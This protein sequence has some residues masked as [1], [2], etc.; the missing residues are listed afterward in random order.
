MELPSIEKCFYL[1]KVIRTHGY[2][3]AL[4]IALDVDEPEHYRDLDIVYIELKKKLIPF[5]IENLHLENNKAN[6]KLE[7]IDSLEQA[8]RFLNAKLFLPLEL[9]PKLK[10]DKFYF[11]EIIGFKVVDHIHGNL[12]V[13]Q[14]VLE[15]PGN[16]LFSIDH[17]GTEVLI[18]IADEIIQ[19]VDRKSKVI[20]IKAPDGLIE[21]YLQ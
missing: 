19:R 8:E 11:H 3:G 10:G 21:L 5:L 16:P 9:L 15:L 17:K 6:L 12:G 18:P 2:K 4:K 20:H 14:K 13:I 1:G 7:D